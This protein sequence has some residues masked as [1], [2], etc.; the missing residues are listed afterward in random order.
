MRII[1]GLCHQV[2]VLNFGETIAEGTPREVRDD[3]A[4]VEAYL[5]RSRVRAHAV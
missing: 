4:V 3:P 5:G 1:S 2:T